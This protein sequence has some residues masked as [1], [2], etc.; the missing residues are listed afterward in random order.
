MSHVLRQ[1]TPTTLPGDDYELFSNM[2][3]SLETRTDLSWRVYEE[4]DIRQTIIAAANRGGHAQKPIAEEPFSIMERVK[5]LNSHWQDLAVASWKPERW[6]DASDT[7]FMKPLIVTNSFGEVGAKL[8]GIGQ[9]N[10][11]DE[12]RTT[13]GGFKLALTPE[14]EAEATRV[15]DKWRRTRDRKVS[16]LKDHPPSPLAWVPVARSDTGIRN[17]WDTL[18]EDGRAR[19]GRSAPASILSGSKQWKPIFRSRDLELIPFDWV[20]PGEEHQTAED[21]KA[22]LEALLKESD[23]IAERRKKQEEYVARLKLSMEE[24]REKT[25]L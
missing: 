11:R 19:A 20:P 2:I 8:G 22:E 14:Q 18:F 23:R 1:L 5:V 13:G 12:I 7:I 9:T 3:R 15:Y 16:Y 24:Q 4:T 25:E 21:S 6:E 17:A 10:T